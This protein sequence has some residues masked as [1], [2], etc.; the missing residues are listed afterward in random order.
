ML[1]ALLLAGA[2]HEHVDGE[3]LGGQ[4]FSRGDIYF[5]EAPW[6]PHGVHLDPAVAAARPYCPACLH[7]VQTSGAHLRPLIGLAPPQF[8]AA[9]IAAAIGTTSEGAAGPRSARGPPARS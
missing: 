7:Q 4:L 8:H 2:L 5:P 6:H 1:A 3:S 9:G